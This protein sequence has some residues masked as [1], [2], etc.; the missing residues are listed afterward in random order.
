MLLLILLANGLIY[1]QTTLSGR[2]LDEQNKALA[3]ASITVENPENNRV[4]AFEMTDEQGD[5]KIVVESTLS[6]LVVRMSSF[7]Y[8]TQ[9]T[10]ITNKTQQVDFT[11]VKEVTQLKE[12]VIKAAL[13][14]QRNDTISYDLN[15]FAGKND[16]VLA[17]VLKKIPGIEVDPTGRI[18]YQGK[19]IN[20]FLV[21]GKDLMGGAYAS[22]TEALPNA[23]VSKLEVI[24]NNQPIKMLK[25]KVASEN[26][27]INI[28]LKKNVTVTGSADMGVGADPA[29]W[30]AKLSP[31]LFNKK[32]QL[33]FNGQSNNFGD[34][35]S[36]GLSDF[37]LPNS[38]D[39][40]FYQRTPGQSLGIAETALPN[41]AAQRYLFNNAHLGA[42]NVLTDVS[43]QTEM[44]VNA[45][46]LNDAVTREGTESTEIRSLDADG[47]TLWKNRYTR[48][49]KSAAFNERLKAVIAFKKNVKNAYLKEEL[50]FQSVRD[51]NRGVLVIDDDA[52]NQTLTSPSFSLQNSLSTLIPLNEKQFVNLK[53]LINYTH[54][55]QNYQ[56]DP[57]EKLT[58]DQ[59]VFKPY[60]ALDQSLRDNSFYTKN[61]ASISWQLKALLVTAEGGMELT[62]R[63]Y[64]SQLYGL[65][66]SQSHYLVSPDYANDLRYFSAISKAG[67]KLNY[68]QK[69]F[70]ANVHL[71][72]KNY[73]IDLQDRAL[74][75]IEKLD[76][77][78]FEPNVF[79]QYDWSTF[80]ALTLSG[81]QQ[82]RFASLEQLYPNFV[83]SQLNFSSYNS[84]IWKSRYRQAATR[85]AYKSPIN[86]VFGDLVYVVSEDVRTV[87]FT[88]RIAENGQQIVDVIARDNAVNG[89]SVSAAIGK[90]FANWRGNASI[91]ADLSVSNS[92]LV[93]NEQ[94]L[95]VKTKSHAVNFKANSNY[96]S[97]LDVSYQLDYQNQ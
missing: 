11:A 46:Y 58:L 94:L 85:I 62:D 50:T 14:T 18:K 70:S 67:L 52:V 51:K 9:I 43:K 6:D 68:K 55:T 59:S 19:E 66:A 83:M 25:G 27:G 15:A 65:D 21:D 2:V 16:R 26:A 57:T 48:T 79:A 5:Y 30:K 86:N 8:S 75:R 72:L 34:D 13:I 64:S 1:G 88:Q 97:W 92:E 47:K 96:W 45:Y 80:W 56:I 22:I 78:V 40:F 37:S 38:F 95:A 42:I 84:D 7:N 90:F 93:V 71:P 74:S 29:L 77:A 87:M 69:R 63:K 33:F 91:R 60:I 41:V 28:K 39:S 36:Y 73:H 54:D 89:Q 20:Q 53:S 49:N 4:L 32:V 35:L 10:A 24:E 76:N 31:M 12:I 82:Y 3:F 17:D 61:E 81:S 44:R 23:A